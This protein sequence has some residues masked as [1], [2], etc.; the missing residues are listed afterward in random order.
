L[1]IFA[2]S[3]TTSTFSGP[4][5]GCDMHWIVAPRALGRQCISLHLHIPKQKCS[6]LRPAISGISAAAALNLPRHPSSAALLRAR[7]YMAKSTRFKAA[8][9][10]RSLPG[11]LTATMTDRRTASRKRSSPTA[12]PGTIRPRPGRRHRSRAVRGAER[13]NEPTVRARE[14]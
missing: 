7:V 3:S 13:N 14:A 1:R 8:T 4:D 2:S 10:T 6:A 5:A 11:Y 9:L 12:A